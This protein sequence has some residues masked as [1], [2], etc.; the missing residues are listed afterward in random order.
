[1]IVLLAGALGFLSPALIPERADAARYVLD[2]EFGEPGSGP[3]QLN[4]PAGLAVAS[5]ENEDS[6]LEDFIYVV[7]QGNDR[8][9]IFDR[10]GTVVYTFPD[11]DNP[12]A[13]FNSPSGIAL[14]EDQSIYLSDTGN[15]RVLHLDGSGGLISEIGPTGGGPSLLSRPSGLALTSQGDLLVSE[16]LAEAGRVSRYLASGEAGP[17]LTGLGRPVGIAVDLAGNLLAA[18]SIGNRIAR[19]TPAGVELPSIGGPGT[20]NAQFDLPF[21]LALAPGGDLLVSDPGN[22]RIQQF[23]SDGAF[24]SSFGS[25]G[26]EGQDPGTPGWLTFGSDGTL[27]V[28]DFVRSVVQRYRFRYDL[29]VNRLGS[30]SGSVS[31]TEAA[32]VCGEVCG[33]GFEPG[34]SVALTATASPGSTFAG[35]SG[36]NC[37]GTGSCA[38]AMSGDQSVTAV[39]SLDRRLSVSLSGNGSGTV[40]SSPGGIQCGADCD[41]TFREGA[42]VTLSARPAAG[43]RFAGWQGA[44]SGNGQCD[45]T[46]GADREV[47]ASFARLP[48]PQIRVTS[49]PP[50]QTRS[51]SAGFRFRSSVPRSTFSC[52]LDR[53]RFQNCRSPK[54]YRRL[55]PGRHRV[56]IRASAAGVSGRAVTV[57]WTIRRR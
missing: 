53:G 34:Q 39:F 9:Q 42:P 4:Q 30:G 15:D 29:A 55:R 41:T 2:S 3:G 45:L 17:R 40:E 54:T 16:P 57:V 1:M 6:V 7:D 51:R 32:L 56:T 44:C 37:T 43:S 35:W 25:F 11:P 49:R 19:F 10:S 46:M 47:T 20:G 24:K 8:V 38:V 12:G 26:P 36:S 27:Y 33:D 52:R 31:V 14:G 50:R 18:D 13:E 28:S 21:A 5:Y 48:V 23:G 22:R